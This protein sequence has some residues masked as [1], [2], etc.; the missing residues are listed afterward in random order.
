V[1]HRC[2]QQVYCHHA[3]NQSGQALSYRYSHFSG[4]LSVPS[5]KIRI[6]QYL[7]EYSTTG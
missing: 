5:R 1:H 7:V 4:C 2:S 3:A 6:R